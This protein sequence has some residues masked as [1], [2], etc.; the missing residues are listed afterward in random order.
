[1]A[2]ILGQRIAETERAAGAGLVIGR[3]SLEIGAGAEEV[4][5][6]GK[7]AVEEIGLGETDVDLLPP[8]RHGQVGAQILTATEQ[9]VLGETDVAQ[10]TFLRREAGAEGELAG[11]SLD[12]LGLDHD[13][14]RRAALF[15]RDVHSIEKSEIA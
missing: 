15:G 13:L 10:H 3:F 12:D 14:V 9:I 2:Q 8:L 7:I 5:A 1:M 6:G 4:E 11:R